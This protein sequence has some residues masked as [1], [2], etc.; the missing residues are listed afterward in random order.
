MFSKGIALISNFISSFGRIGPKRSQTGQ[1]DAPEGMVLIPEGPFLMGAPE[2]GNEN[3]K[4]CHTVFLNAFYIDKYPVT[5]EEYDRFCEATGRPLADDEGTGR[6]KHPVINVSWFD[7]VDYAA[8]AGKRLPTEA[9]WE[10]AARAGTSTYYFWTKDYYG[11]GGEDYLWYKDNSGNQIHPVGQKKPNPFGL[12][13]MMGLV[14]E[15]CSDW[16]AKSYYKMS[17]EMNPKGPIEGDDRDDR[18]EKSATG[19]YRKVMRG[20]SWLSEF[21]VMSTDCRG[22]MHPGC[23]S[24][25]TGFRCVKDVTPLDPQK[26]ARKRPGIPKS[27]LRKSPGWALVVE[28]YEDLNKTNKVWGPFW[29][30]SQVPS[31]L[32]LWALYLPATSMGT[33]FISQTEEYVPG[34]NILKI[35]YVPTQ[36]IFML[37]YL[38]LRLEPRSA[39]TGP[40]HARPTKFTLEWSIFSTSKNGSQRLQKKESF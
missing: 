14:Y 3:S 23:I 18:L 32:P 17:P 21:D 12:Y 1:Q 2:D 36:N 25:G 11:V 9:E 10:K 16:Y 8:W 27:L 4:P 6:G 38:E 24:Q 7:A 15:W 20:G 33:L 40:K 39:N 29:D 28:S 34:Q 22:D 31:L 30:P 13:D 37:E 35:N 19:Y 26:M 5:F